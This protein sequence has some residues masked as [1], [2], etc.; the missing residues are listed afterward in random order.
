MNSAGTHHALSTTTASRRSPWF[1]SVRCLSCFRVPRR[2]FASRRSHCRLNC[3]NR[4]GLAE[5][6]RRGF[7]GYQLEVIR[8]YRAN[9]TFKKWLNADARISNIAYEGVR[10]QDD[11]I[12]AFRVLADFGYSGFE[13]GHNGAYQPT[14]SKR[15][16]IPSERVGISN[17]R[18]Q[19]A[20]FK[21][22]R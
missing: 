7:W 14:L 1:K 6:N 21:D 11:D 13:R 9:G 4:H 12:S 15:G 10:T 2:P 8:L 5:L 16:S 17:S 22:V 19:F 18:R 20:P 3:S